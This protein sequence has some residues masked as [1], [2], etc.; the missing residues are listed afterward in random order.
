VV[1][2]ILEQI[3]AK[4]KQR[5]VCFN[6]I[7]E[8]TPQALDTLR[9][10]WPR[11]VCIS[12]KTGEGLGD[13]LHAFAEYAARD[14]Q[15]MTVLLPYDAGALANRMHETCQIIHEQYE[16]EGLL[17]TIKAPSRIAPLL[18]RYRT[19]EEAGA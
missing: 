15:V 5:L 3:G 1:N 6:K 13:L 9:M 17:A 11:A 16:Q 10:G 19:S 14:A 18:E 7:D 4:D 8:L 2:E 12:A